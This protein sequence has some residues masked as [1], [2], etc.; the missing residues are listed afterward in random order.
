M[1]ELGKWIVLHISSLLWL[2]LG[3][4]IT[5]S[6]HYYP[7]HESK[8]P[9]KVDCG[10]TPTMNLKLGVDLYWLSSADVSLDT[11][12][13]ISTVY[14]AN[15]SCENAPIYLINT[16]E[17]YYPPYYMVKGSNWTAV[18]PKSE[19]VTFWF[20]KSQP[21]SCSNVNEWSCQGNQDS[22]KICEIVK[23][24]GITRTVVVNETDYYN[25]CSDPP[26]YDYPPSY[27]NFT[28]I[29][30]NRSAIKNGSMISSHQ[31]SSDQPTASVPLMNL[32][33]FKRREMCVFMD[34]GCGKAGEFSLNIEAHM[35]EDIM[36][37]ILILG[38]L[39]AVV[40]FAITLTIHIC[41]WKMFA[42]AQPKINKDLAPLV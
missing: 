4:I 11:N 9:V 16:A 18:N 33:E 21:L 19:K 26:I 37:L 24:G 2:L 12:G 13:G 6:L 23:P 22:D 41:H 38:L 17:I 36:L 10:Q 34:L 5:V 35:R 25:I 40:H 30:Y 14:L 20:I 27:I 1:K 42:A 39:M 8:S 3:A 28:Y 15:I 7:K 31:I 29:A 32:F